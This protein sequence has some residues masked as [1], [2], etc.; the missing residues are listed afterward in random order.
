[1]STAI[2]DGTNVAVPGAAGYLFFTIPEAGT[3]SIYA[4]GGSG[5]YT[6]KTSKAGSAV[7]GDFVFASGDVIWI[8][9]GGLGAYGNSGG[10]D[11]AGGAGGGMTVV[12]RS[13]SKSKTFVS[14]DMT[15][16]LCAAGGLGQTEGRHGA[17]AADSNA[18]DG[19]GGSGFYGSWLSQSFNGSGAGYGGQ[20]TYGGFGGG[21][22]TDDG[23]G[24]AGGYDGLFSGGPNSYVSPTA[25]NV[26]RYNADPLRGAY[27]QGYVRLTKL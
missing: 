3:W 7:G 16:L 17:Y 23:Y 18:S 13:S 25:S 20:T 1:M 6:N 11:L 10:S 24:G 9:I 21:T 22:G 19:A 4:I 8:S 15:P 26:V 12:A 5:G 2:N 14:G 27:N